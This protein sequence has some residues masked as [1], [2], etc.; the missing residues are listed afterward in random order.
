MMRHMML[1]AMVGAL[2]LVLGGCPKKEGADPTKAEPTKAEP[3][4][5]EPKKEEPKVEPK[6]EEPKAEP[7]AETKTDDKAEGGTPEENCGAAYDFAKQMMEAFASKL[8]KKD[9]A[10]DLPPRDKYVAACKELPPEV[11][12]CMNPKVAMKEGQKCAEVMQ[13]VDKEKLAKLKAM[14]KK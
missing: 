11:T 1:L 12:R 8:G 13:K 2:G 4:K 9:V 3:T 5:V 7:K 14:M 10:K 6:K